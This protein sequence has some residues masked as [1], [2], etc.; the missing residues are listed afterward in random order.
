MNV[1]GEGCNFK[2]DDQEDLTVKVTFEQ[3]LV[4]VSY[5]YFFRCGFTYLQC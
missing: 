3:S 1:D 2:Q 5:V 4:E